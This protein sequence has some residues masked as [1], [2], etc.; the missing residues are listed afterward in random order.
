MTTIRTTEQ[1]QD[2]MVLSLRHHVQRTITYQ[3][4]AL[5]PPIEELSPALRAKLAEMD[6]LLELGQRQMPFIIQAPS[7]CLAEPP[8]DHCSKRSL[9]VAGIANRYSASAG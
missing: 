5:Y 4:S 1:V 6:E 3:L 8:S 9:A 2:Q 7:D